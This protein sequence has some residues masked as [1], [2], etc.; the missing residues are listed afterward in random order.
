MM[1]L[2]SHESLVMYGEQTETWPRYRPGREWRAFWKCGP[3]STDSNITNVKWA[4]GVRFYRVPWPSTNQPWITETVFLTS[5]PR[6]KPSAYVT[7]KS[8]LD[9]SWSSALL[10]HLLISLFN[11]VTGPQACSLGS[12]S[13]VTAITYYILP[14]LDTAF[15]SQIIVFFWTVI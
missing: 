8:H 4:E 14:F 11:I 3:V 12:Q 13:T 9:T 1:R 15:I 7:K 5:H 10:E 6:F 2:Q